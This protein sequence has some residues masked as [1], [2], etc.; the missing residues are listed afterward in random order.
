[1]ISLTFEALLLV[2]TGIGAGFFAAL[3]FLILLGQY[4]YRS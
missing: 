1:M 3:A 4:L 2:G